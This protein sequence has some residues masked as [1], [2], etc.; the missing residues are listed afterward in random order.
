[1]CSSST[2]YIC[3]NLKLGDGALVELAG[4]V[5]SGRRA[6]SIPSRKATSGIAQGRA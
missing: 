2:G 1:M 5:E 3:W 6:V 4:L